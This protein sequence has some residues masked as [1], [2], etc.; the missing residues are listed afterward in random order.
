G[1]FMNF[2][3][4]YRRQWVLLKPEDKGTRIL[5]A[6]SD[7]RKNIDF[8]KDFAVFSSELMAATESKPSESER[9][10]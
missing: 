5:L 4:H 7:I 6:G 8:D 1:I 10:A 3:I 9:P 2:Y